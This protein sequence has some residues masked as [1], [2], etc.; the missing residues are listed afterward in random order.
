MTAIR[1]IQSQLSRVQTRRKLMI[2]CVSILF[3]PALFFTTAYFKTGSWQ[4][5]TIEL[6]GLLL[7]FTAIIGR[8]CCT[9]YIG[10]R[11]TSSLIRSGPYSVC[12]NPLYFF[13][14]M[15]TAGLGMQTGSLS[16]ALM[17]VLL[18]YS[19]FL[20]VVLRE[21]AGLSSVHGQAYRDYRQSVP[22]F[23]PNLRLWRDVETVT[24]NPRVWTRTVMD[25]MVFILLAVAIRAGLLLQ[26]MRAD[27]PLLTLY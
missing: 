8:S 13:S 1:E 2:W 25:G 20:A 7:I 4:R 9:L 5:V 18:A 23:M 21:E 24:V 11:K 10:G 19:I 6:V 12:R 22:R 15:A 3:I 17:M 14:F 26:P 16:L 27:F